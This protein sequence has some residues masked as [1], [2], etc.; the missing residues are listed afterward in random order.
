LSGGGIQGFT[1]EKPGYH[2]RGTP[3]KETDSVRR[4][5]NL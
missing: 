3:A 4:R 2:L 5:Q 1:N